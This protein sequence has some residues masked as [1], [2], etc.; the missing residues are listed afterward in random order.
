MNEAQGSMVFF[1]FSLLHAG[2]LKGAPLLWAA[3][4]G[5]YS[6]R[7]G[8]IN[9]GLEGMML[10]GAFFGVVGAGLTGSP[11]IGVLLGAIAG[12]M[13]G[14][15]HAG[16][17]LHGQA[18]QIVSGIGINLFAIGVTGFLLYKIFDARGNSPEV[19]KLPV[20]IFSPLHI[21]LILIVISTVYL[22][23]KTRFGLRLRACGENPAVV[24]SAGVSVGL[25][26]YTAVTLS[27][28]FA[29]L[30]G[31]QL[32]LG[33]VSQFSIEMTNGRG[34]IALAALICSGWRPGRAALVCI[35]FGFMEALSE[36]LQSVYP[37]LPSRAM[38]ALP[39]VLALIVLSF[40]RQTSH[41]PQS[42][43]KV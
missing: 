25:Y 24:H 15:I 30:G 1:A 27:G 39:F 16:V 13:L 18:N 22:F 36:Y 41:A 7:S 14:L 38:L 28:V 37:N 20:F 31:V 42:L 43:G 32:S 26:R 6:E 3:I 29:G 4:G 2:F 21:A 35:F 33:D 8:V 9:V 11:W 23:Y 5:A 40:S 19:E 10:T 34:F 17:C 12:G